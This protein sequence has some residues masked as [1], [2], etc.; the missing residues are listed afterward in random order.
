MTWS[1]RA[2]VWH[3]G[4]NL[5]IWSERLVGALVS[6]ED[7]VPGYDQDL[8][9]AAREYEH[10]SLAGAFWSLS[11]AAEDWLPVIQ[12]AIERDVVLVHARRGAQPAARVAQNNAHDAVH[13]DWDVRRILESAGRHNPTPTDS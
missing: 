7:E 4:D 10:S 1:V 8:L 9:A 2:Y 6:G 3:V 11:G 13:H 12:T 5:R